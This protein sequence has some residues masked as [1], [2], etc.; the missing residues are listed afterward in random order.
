MSDENAPPIEVNLPW[1]RVPMC[2][3]DPGYG[4]PPTKLKMLECAMRGGSCREFTDPN[5]PSNQ[6]E[7][8]T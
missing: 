1:E 5:H 3:C 4:D 2:G 6:P 8:T 7:T